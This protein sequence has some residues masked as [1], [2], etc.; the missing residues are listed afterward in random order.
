MT[1]MMMMMIMMRR[2]MMTNCHDDD[3]EDDDDDDGDDD[4]DDDQLWWGGGPPGSAETER[5]GDCSEEHRPCS[6][7]SEN[8]I[9]DFGRLIR[10]AGRARI[11]LSKVKSV[12]GTD[13]QRAPNLPFRCSDETIAMVAYWRIDLS[14]TM[15]IQMDAR[16]MRR[17]DHVECWW[18]GSRNSLLRLAQPL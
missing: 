16:T 3:G 6:K 13:G 18:S 2:V 9:I 4:D 11:R 5:R 14:M 17:A 7:P 10:S 15:K 12:W 1:M 8:A